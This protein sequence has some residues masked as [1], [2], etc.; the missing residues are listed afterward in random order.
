M[1]KLLGR[2]KGVFSGIAQRVAGTPANAVSFAFGMATGIALEPLFRS[3]RYEMNE[4]LPTEVLTPDVTARLFRRG[5]WDRG[6]AVEELRKHGFDEDRAN[7]F[8]SLVEDYLSLAE[9]GSLWLRGKITEEEFKKYA[10]KHGLSEKSFEQTKELLNI[11]P[12]VSDLIRFSVREVFTPETRQ[13]FGMDE[14]FPEEFAEWAKKQGLSEEWAKA[15]WAAHWELPSLTAGYEM[16]HRRIIDRDT[17]SMLMKAQDVMPYWRDK[18]MELSYRPLTRVDVRRMY[19]VGVLSREE[20][21]N[22]YLDVGYSPENAERMTDFTI[23]Y[24]AAPERDL[25]KAEILR[26]YRTGLLK[27]E[28]AKGKLSLLGYDDDEVEFY[29]ESE[30]LKRVEEEK[31]EILKLLEREY[32]A[33]VKTENEV[34]EVLTQHD[35]VADEIERLLELWSLAK[36]VKDKQPGVKTLLTFHKAGVITETQLREELENQGYAQKYIEWYIKSLRKGEEV[37]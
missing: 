33:G 5:V 31:K 34:R 10:A 25:T 36:I 35:F 7:S 14:D 16:F 15:Y 29:I 12:P 1:L 22:A 23:S 28:E 4:K 26:G 11:I 30:N 13:E 18:L 6:K 20:V 8:L 24:V 21:Y 37:E 9:Y 3:F 2:L 17:L 32:R 27:E 19:Q